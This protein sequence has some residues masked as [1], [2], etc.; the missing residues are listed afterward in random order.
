MF[1][2]PA[3]DTSVGQGCSWLDQLKRL[4]IIFKNFPSFLCVA[5]LSNM[6]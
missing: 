3:G 1:G 5:Q 2:A 4:K 6:S